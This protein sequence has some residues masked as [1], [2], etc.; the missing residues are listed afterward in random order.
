MNGIKEGLRKIPI[1]FFGFG[2]PSGLA[3]YFGGWS[4]VLVLVAWRGYEE[5]LDFREQRDTLGKAVIDFL[6][7][8]AGSVVAGVLR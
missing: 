3:V 7:Q 8:T 2:I 1:H 4:G 6:S 5:Y